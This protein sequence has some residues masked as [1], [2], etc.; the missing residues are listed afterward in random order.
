MMMLQCCAGSP[1]QPSYYISRHQ[2][3]FLIAMNFTVP[4]IAQ[5]LGVSR[6]TVTRRMNTFGIGVRQM[7]SRISDDRL[8]ELVREI[9]MEFPRAGYRFIRSHLRARGYRITERRV[10]HSLGRID[11][12]AVAVRWTTHNAIHR[13]VYRVPYPNAVWHMDSNMSLVRWGFVVHGAVDGYSRLI[14]YLHCSSNN[15]ANTV[16]HLF[17]QAGGTY[18]YPSRM[19][20]DQGG[21][22]V[23]VARLMLLLRGCN[24]GSH[25][26]GRSVNNIRIERLW[27]DVFSQCLSTYYHLFY[28]M[29]DNGILDPDNPIHLFALHYIF[30]IRINSS[31]AS[32]TEAWNGHPLR[33]ANNL[34]PFQL[35]IRG[36]M[37]HSH[38]INPPIQ[39]LTDLDDDNINSSS[40]HDTMLQELERQVNPS[41]YSDTW[42]ID[43]Y[44]QTLQFLFH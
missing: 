16:L 34:S 8:D 36:I 15:R 31:L 10:R 13:R 32:F 29:E 41:D 11:P 9:T 3:Q 4:A 1:G 19:R 21:E 2:L 37:H 42:G 30:M 39:E 40:S 17:I 14:V 5:L 12:T 24:R 33:T 28:F 20:S 18:G 7:Y 22:N 27:R 38:E 6:A 43:L 26:T 25:I 35:W 23:D 44:V